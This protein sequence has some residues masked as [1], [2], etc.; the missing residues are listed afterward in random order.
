ML[1]K[2]A[3]IATAIL[4]SAST[5]FG[6]GFSIYEQGA[7]ATAMA[8]AFIAQANDASAVF[9]NPAGITSLDDTQLSIGTAIIMPSFDFQ[10]PTS[11]DPNLYTKA[12]EGV[13]PPTHLY[14]TYKITDEL[15]AGFGFFTLFGLGSEWPGDWIGRELATFSEVQTFTLNPNLA[16]KV[17]DALSVS[18]GF[19][20]IVGKVIL[21]STTAYVGLPSIET[22][23]ESKLEAS[24]TGFGYNLGVQYKPVDGLT[25]GAVYRSNV[26]LEFEDGDASFTWKDGL[27]ADREALLRGLF[28]D[29]LKGSSELELPNLIGL[30]IAYDVTDDIT[31]EF[32]FMQLGWSSY[33]KLTVNFDK[34]VGPDKIKTEVAEKNYEDSYSLRFGLEYRMDEKLALRAGYLRDNHAVPD[35]FVEPTLPEG[36]RNLY[37][38]GAGYNFGDIQLD[39]FYVL[40]T[41][42]ERK[43]TTSKV[44][45]TED[46]NDFFNGT[47][48]G[49]ANMFGLSLSYTLK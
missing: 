15:V 35:A 3:L 44:K 33:D 45:L 27:S 8:G 23:V 38:L 19:Q 13:F 18:V 48:R 12:K 39:A 4:L 43:I 29:N 31:A 20:Y 24:G 28:P 32:D 22:Y 21:E 37:S 46:G 26:L 16:Y 36:D 11:V 14:A 30:G 1:R 34:P 47:Y 10:G 9:Y 25:I 2:F 49:I 7:K 17:S 40:L 41:Q 6:S 42:D 5:A